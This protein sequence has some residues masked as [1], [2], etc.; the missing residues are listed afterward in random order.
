M[1]HRFHS[2]EIDEA[3]REL[4]AGARVLPLQPLVFDLLLYL[5]KNRG[6]VVPKD[7]LLD[8][9]WP[10]VTVA[11]GSLQRAVSLARAAVAEAG[12]PDVIR[13]HARRGYRFSGRDAGGEDIPS[14]DRAENISALERAHSAYARRDWLEA[15][16]ALEEVDRLEG[17]SAGDLQRWAQAAQHA[18][19]SRRAFAPLERAVAAYHKSGDR[20]RAVWVAIHLAQLRMEWRE[21]VLAKGWYHRA[22]RLLAGEP[23][24]REQGYLSLVGCG[25]ALSRNEVET[26]LELAESA[27]EMGERFHDLIWKAWDWFMSAKPASFSVGFA[28]GWP[29]SMKPGRR[30]WLMN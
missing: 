29:R 22:S 16:T 13:T 12:A 25:L 26:A 20:A 1:V 8:T 17:L 9:I 24:C 7:E 19:R 5:A 2:F 11:E 14:A 6:R 23:P 27:R 28:R 10:G 18:G 4:R 3:A 30:L 15:I 21:P